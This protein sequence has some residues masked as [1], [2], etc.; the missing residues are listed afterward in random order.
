MITSDSVTVPAE[1]PSILERISEFFVKMV[2]SWMP[3]AYLWAIILT[4]IVFIGSAIIDPH[5]VT[6]F[7]GYWY[8]G[9]YSILTFTLQGALI[10]VTGFTLAQ[11]PPVRRALERLASWPK[12]QRQAAVIVVECSAIAMLISWGL[13]LVV[14]AVL[15]REMA[16]R[17]PKVNFAFL[18]AAGYSSI[19]VWASGLSSAIALATASPGNPLNIIQKVTGHVIPLSGTLLPA[20]NVVPTLVML[21]AL[22]LLFAAIAPGR[23]FITE[24][25]RQK[26]IIED[27]Q[28]TSDSSRL[29]VPAVWIENAPIFTAILVVLI[30]GAVWTRI[31]A[32]TFALTFNMLITLFIFVGLLLHARPIRFVQAFLNST[33][34]AGPIILQY[35]LYGGMQGIMVQSGLAKL[36]SSWFVG[37]SS[38]HTLPF[39]A[40]LGSIVISMFVPS[41][42][43]HWVVQGP[44]QVPAAA[45]LHASQGL[46]AMAVAWGEQVADMIQPFWVLPVLGIV[47]LGIRQVM[48]Y[49]TLAFFL[50]LLVFGGAALVFGLL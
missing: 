19:I 39:F 28:A 12:T 35:P 42:G 27:Q 37:F 47:G 5:D 6:Q 50:G 2:T 18:V 1:R 31:A 13:G 10:A 26:L 49:C 34:A 45:A 20:F 30:V 33:R 44:V 32:G 8:T 21:V 46:T 16:K 17:V 40:F 22:P 43:G 11:A 4:A 15:A 24:E 48:G 36:V 3:D 25:E 41:G 7:F 14:A 23:G 9:M 38:A 29:P